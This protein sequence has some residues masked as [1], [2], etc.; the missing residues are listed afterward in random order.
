M[1]LTK[2]RLVRMGAEAGFYAEVDT[3]RLERLAREVLD[4]IQTHINPDNDEYEIGLWVAPMCKRVLDGTIRLPVPHL[5][6]PLSYPVREGLLPLDFQE[7]FSEFRITACGMAL[8][9]SE[10]I[11]VDGVSYMVADFEE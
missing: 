11:V 1:R 6:L 4:Y 8:E 3:V 5:D 10:E 9:I 2:R 7:L